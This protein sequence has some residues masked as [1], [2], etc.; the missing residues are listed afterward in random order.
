MVLDQ[1]YKFDA[2]EQLSLLSPDVLKAHG[3]S[4]DSLAADK[5]FVDRLWGAYQKSVEEYGVDP[6]YAVKDALQDILDIPMSEWESK[7]DGAPARRPVVYV[8]SPYAGD[9]AGNVAFAKAAAIYAVDQGATPVVPHLQYPAILE[10]AD[11]SQ[12]QLGLEMDCQLLGKCDELWC[13]DHAGVSPGML[14]E[15]DFASE[16]GIPVK[17]MPG[18]PDGYLERAL[19]LPW[20]DR[21]FRASVKV[22]HHV[23]NEETGVLLRSYHGVSALVLILAWTEAQANAKLDAWL[24]ETYKHYDE[25]SR[26]I[27]PLVPGNS[28]GIVV[29]ATIV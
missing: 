16:N 14:A 26:R 15:I 18:L 1:S 12:R 5:D 2:L 11:P 22:D 25:L 8:C 3:H 24:K 17:H 6:D 23:F 29:Q 9:V 20:P 21:A 4:H 10:D 27:E 13:F 28:H 7:N 19:A